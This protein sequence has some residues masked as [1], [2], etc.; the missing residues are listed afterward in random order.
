MTSGR[1]SIL[2]NPNLTLST[3]FLLLFSHNIHTNNRR[4]LLYQTV[5]GQSR[6]NKPN[7]GIVYLGPHRF[8]PRSAIVSTSSSYAYPRR[9]KDP[10]FRHQKTAT[11]ACS[12]KDRHHHQ[13]KPKALYLRIAT[14]TSYHRSRILYAAT[15]ALRFHLVR[16]VL[17]TDSR[18]LNLD[19]IG[20]RTLEQQPGASL[21]GTESGPGT[22]CQH[23]TVSP[24]YGPF[25]YQQNHRIGVYHL[26]RSSLSGG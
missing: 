4:R 14:L 1:L 18:H 8:N 22:P 25:R 3:Y 10:C 16:K 6:C 24:V 13:T 17:R 23:T 7:K 26:I 15:P 5:N 20:R 9:S 21:K 12:H 2:S 11:I 19:V